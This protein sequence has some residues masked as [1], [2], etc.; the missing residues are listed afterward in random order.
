LAG[1]NSS[2]GRDI[3]AKTGA[4]PRERALVG[5]ET[6]QAIAAF[7]PHPLP[8]SVRVSDRSKG[9]S[10]RFLPERGLEV[11]TPPGV[12][13]DYLVAA[14]GQRREWLA[15]V[16]ERLAAEGGLPTG[17]APPRPERLV[18]TA[19]ARQWRVDYLPREREGC[20][21]TVRGPESVVVSGRCGTWRPCPGC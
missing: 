17:I 7:L 4:S 9:V 3:G 10:L 5:P 20:L 12:P 15:R 8:V 14:V 2:P 6:A 18:L 21:L 13:S 16:C 19:F 1:S 11:V